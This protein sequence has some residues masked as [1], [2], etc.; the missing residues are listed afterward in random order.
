MTLIRPSISE[1]QPPANSGPSETAPRIEIVIVNY[2]T[3]QLTIDCVRSLESLTGP[4]PCVIVVDNASGDNSM[5]LLRAKLAADVVLVESPTNG[6]YTAGNNLGFKVAIERGCEFVHALN[7]DTVV[8]NPNYLGD[9]LKHL[10]AN[11]QTG[12]V[13]PRVHF[14]KPGVVQN[15]ILRFPWLWR[16]AVDAVRYR[17]RKPAPRSKDKVVDVEALNG[18]CVLFRTTCL[19]HVGGFDDR[20]FA[21]VDE[22]DWSL[23]AGRAGWKLQYVPVDSVVHLQ[24]ESG[25]RRAGLVDFLLKRNTVFFLLKNRR[26]VQAAGYTLA[27]GAIGLSL[28]TVARFRRSAFDRVRNWNRDLF[29]AYWWLWTAQ[30]DRAMGRP[31]M[32]EPS[33]QGGMTQ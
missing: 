29:Q 25:Y 15:T 19:Q 13:G 8:L 26:F 4:K 16:R 18:V 22:V 14:R 28:A 3:P 2:R 20:I 5:E 30:W 27:T 33:L 11:P 12:A 7:P 31:P 10:Q 32:A 9:L 6:G 23:R 21:Y 1:Q 24:K 17:I